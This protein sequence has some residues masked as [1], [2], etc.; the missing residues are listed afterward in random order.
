MGSFDHGVSLFSRLFLH[1][2]YVEPDSVTIKPS[3]S[4]A[5]ILDQGM[6]VTV[7]LSSFIIYSFAS[8]L[9][10]PIPLK[11]SIPSGNLMLTCSTIS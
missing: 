1:Q 10:P 9:Y 2:V 6:G 11:N 3:S 7:F 4:L 8:W 5:I